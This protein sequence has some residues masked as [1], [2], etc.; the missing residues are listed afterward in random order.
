MSS[1]LL[2]I[3][4]RWA[5]RQA[6]ELDEIASDISKLADE[7]LKEGID[8]VAKNWKSNSSDKFQGKCREVQ[9]DTKGAADYVRNIASSV[10]EI[11]RAAEE[12]EREARRIA[13]ERSSDWLKKTVN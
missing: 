7:K 13:R 5:Y 4:Y 6:D 3:D 9:S 8:T 12:A 2:E 10:R 1:S 11:A